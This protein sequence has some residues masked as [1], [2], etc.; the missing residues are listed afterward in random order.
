MKPSRQIFA[1]LLGVFVALGMNLSA[2]RASGMAAK[3]IVTPGMGTSGHGDC[4]GCEGGDSGGAKAMA[5]GSIC[6]AP[7]IALPPQTFS[8][9]VFPARAMSLRQ[10]PHPHDRA[11]P[12]DPYPPRPGDLG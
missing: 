3:M 5:C 8:M 2:V 10:Y 4:R 12:P 11:S 6:I 7:V 1:L 9:S